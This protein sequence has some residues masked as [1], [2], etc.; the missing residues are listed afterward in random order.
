MTIL[1]TG[2]KLGVGIVTMVINPVLTTA[3]FVLNQ[4]S[5]EKIYT[6]KSS[7]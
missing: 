4:I 6:A 2:V 5:L 1:K 3:A 7:M